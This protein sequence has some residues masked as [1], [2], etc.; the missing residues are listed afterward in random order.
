MNTPSVTTSM[1]VLA[2]RLEPKR[3][4]RP[5]RLADRLL[6]R[7]RHP[8]RRRAGRQPP[9]LQHQDAPALGPWLLRRAPAAPAWSCRRRAAPPAPPCC[10][11][12]ALPSVPAARHR[13]AERVSKASMV[14][15][16]LIRVSHV[17]NRR[18]R[19]STMLAYDCV[20]ARI[21]PAGRPDR[22]GRLRQ[23]LL[24]RHGG[25]D[26]LDARRRG[27]GR[28]RGL[29]ASA[30]RLRQAVPH[31]GLLH[32]LR[33]VSRPRHR[34]R[35]AHLSRPQ[36]RALRLFL[37][38]VGDHPVRPQGPGDRRR[39]R[40]GWRSRGNTDSP[41]SIRSARCGSSICCRSSS[42]SSSWRASSGSRRCWSGSSPPAWKSRMS[43]PAGWCRT[44]SP[45]ASS[46]SIPAMCWRDRSSRSPPGCRRT[47][48]WRLADCWSGPSWKRAR[49]ISDVSELPL[50]SL[51]LGLVGAAAVMSGAALMA[52][53]DC[54]PAA[55]L[56]RAQLHRHLSR[57]L[58]A[59]G[60]DPHRAAEDRH[61]PRCRRHGHRH[62]RRRRD[63]RRCCCSGRC[64][65]RR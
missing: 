49:S 13:S 35:L 56:L 62:H 60:G 41:S 53:H 14:N 5:T 65:I 2:D 16:R 44:S 17:D 64:A 63:R 57:L 1:R 30:G 47:H 54:L 21:H 22:L 46:I 40:L 10:A 28:A 6:K 39:R 50:V 26:A 52:R 34:P 51:A 59:D 55:A 48:G 43:T 3:T 33:P 18:K 15:E 32:D 9:W 61:R 11:R 37:R 24:H 23:R 20:H 58:P 36:G 45:R 19:A 27:R 42:S 25:D 29:H 12:R 31:A 8:R 38:A 4:R 7:C